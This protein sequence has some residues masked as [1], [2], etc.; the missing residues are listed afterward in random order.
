MLSSVIIIIV[1]KPS[2]SSNRMVWGNECILSVQRVIRPKVHW[3]TSTTTIESGIGSGTRYLT[4]PMLGLLPSKE[5]RCKDFGKPSK[6]CHV[7]IHWKVLA[8][9]FQMSTHLSGVQSIS[10]FSASFC[11]GQV[12]HQQHKG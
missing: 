4:L 3:G 7:G 2:S 12:S 5:Q 6:P 1:V 11:I 10:R 8:E 9:Y